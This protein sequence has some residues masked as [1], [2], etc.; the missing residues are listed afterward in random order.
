MSEEISQV[1]FACNGE[2]N[3]AQLY[4]LMRFSGWVVC[5]YL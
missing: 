2:E 5:G 1:D 4:E 3:K